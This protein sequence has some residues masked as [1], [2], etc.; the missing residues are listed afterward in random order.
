MVLKRQI[1]KMQKFL[2]LE[3]V[4]FSMEWVFVISEPVFQFRLLLL[5]SSSSSSSLSTPT[6]FNIYINEIIEKSNQIY[7]KVMILSTTTNIDTLLFAGEQVI[8]ANS[9][10]NLQGGVFTLQNT[11]KSIG[12]EKSPEKSETMAFLGK[13]SANC[14]II[15]YNKCLK[16]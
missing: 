2:D 11:A 5:S 16:Q 7:T 6:L 13:D 3:E 8:I 10:D 9:E 15:V 4:L 12:M 14:T 1:S